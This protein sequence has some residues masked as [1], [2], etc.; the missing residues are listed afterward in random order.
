MLRDEIR[1][2]DAAF[3]IADE[4][5]ASGHFTGDSAALET[6]RPI[7]GIVCRLQELSSTSRG[8]VGTAATTAL[9]LLRR[10]APAQPAA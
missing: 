7:A 3:R 9:D 1:L 6:L 10:E 4:Q 5:I 2:V 8:Q